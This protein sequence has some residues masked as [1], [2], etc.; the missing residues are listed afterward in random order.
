M[1]DIIVR[2]F[3]D[4]VITNLANGNQNTPVECTN[5]MIGWSQQEGG[6]I[7]NS[8]KYNPLNCGYKATGSTQFNNSGV[9]VYKDPAS[10]IDA[11]TKNLQ[12]APYSA[13]SHALSTGD[14]IGLGFTARS[15]P[16]FGH[17][18]SR[19]VASGLSMWVSGTTDIVAH[20]DYILSVMHNAGIPN[21][22]I[23]GGT[24]SGSQAGQSQSGIDAY[25]NKSLGVD[26]SGVTVS[27]AVNNASNPLS[28]LTAWFSQW[29]QNDVLKVLGGSLLLLV[30]MALFIKMQFPTSAIA[31]KLP[32]PF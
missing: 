4:Q 26:T 13:L 14:L 15:A 9:Q 23:E 5:F 10:A 19:D 30:A 11:T 7:T 16:V 1:A 22:S 31:K 2:A 24:K 6:G 25:G 18:M 28:G 8:A 17:M 27:G 21:P 12:E 3:C 20:Q 32:I 29:T